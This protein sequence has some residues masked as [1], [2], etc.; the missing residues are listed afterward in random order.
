MIRVLR[1]IIIFILSY[2]IVACNELQSTSYEAICTIQTRLEKALAPLKLPNSDM[3]YPMSMWSRLHWKWV[4]EIYT[5]GKLQG[6]FLQ[7]AQE[8][9]YFAE[10]AMLP[11]NVWRVKAVTQNA[12]VL[13]NQQSQTVYLHYIHDQA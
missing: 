13:Q 11:D 4:G 12:V 2:L 5:Q 1:W 7:A 9:F 6:V 3:I 10:S 8:S